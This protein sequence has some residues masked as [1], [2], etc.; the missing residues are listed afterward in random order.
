[1]L[2]FKDRTLLV[3]LPAVGRIRL[4][5]PL[6]LLAGALSLALGLSAASAKKL[7]NCSQNDTSLHWEAVFGHVTSLDQAIVVQ[8]HLAK[9]GYKNIGFERDACDDIE[10]QVPGVDTPAQR[11]S[12]AVEASRAQV[13]VSFEAPDN[14]KTVG[15][16]EATA[17]FGR[18][19]TLKRANTL[20]LAMA[21]VGFRENADIVR[22]GIHNW[23][24]V[25]YRIPKS[26]S[27]AFA[28]EARKSHFSVTFQG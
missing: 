11:S 19:P 28:A 4:A 1:M 18:L 3:Q 2:R 14:V 21:T 23:M 8:K 10:I 12:F 17:V 22:L 27:S 9:L 20:L 15:P 6:G 7:D 13:P 24:V 5:I 25:M 26:V 16:G